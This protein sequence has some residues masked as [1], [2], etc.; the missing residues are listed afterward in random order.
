MKSE[1]GSIGIMLGIAVIALVSMI[2][3]AILI[4]TQQSAVG[5]IEGKVTIGPIC[6]VQRIDEPCDTS[7]EA[8]DTRKILVYK[9]N[10]I[11]KKIS[12]DG[13]G[14]FRTEL[15]TGTYAVDINHIGIDRSNDVPREIV[16]EAGKTTVL[17]ID[18]DTGIR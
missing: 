11:V 9:N 10:V 15:N 13:E 16:I 17:N 12:L 14:N 5:I 3:G 18:I 2:A 7:P 1:K 8:F 4:Q 6:P